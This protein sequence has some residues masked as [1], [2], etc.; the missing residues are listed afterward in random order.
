MVNTILKEADL[1]FVRTAFGLI[2]Q[3][4]ISKKPSIPHNRGLFCVHSASFKRTSIRL[5]AER[6][7]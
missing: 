4:T 6:V 2:L 5:K 1:F 7:V 3:S